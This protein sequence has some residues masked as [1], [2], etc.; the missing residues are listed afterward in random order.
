MDVE[1]LYTFAFWGS[2]VMVLF[3]A[4]LGLVGIWFEDFFKYKIVERLF[5]TDGILFATAL[6]VTI[7]T[8]LLR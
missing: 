8:K 3:G 7:I 5:I 1:T 2:I 6:A 4:A